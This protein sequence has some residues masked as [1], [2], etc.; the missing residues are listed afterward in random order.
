MHM[1]RHV[2]SIGF[3]VY[4][5]TLV[6]SLLSTNANAATYYL[7][8]VGSDSQSGTSSSTPWKTFHFAIPKLHPGD[9]L[10]LLDGKYTKPIAV[11]RSSPVVAMPPMGRPPNPLP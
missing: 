9:T 3:L 5:L 11:C 6:A 8:P 1:K 2:L 4:S 10:L 7:S